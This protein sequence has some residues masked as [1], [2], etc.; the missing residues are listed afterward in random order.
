MTSS[1]AEDWRKS[2]ELLKTLI[3]DIKRCYL[4]SLIKIVRKRMKRD[5]HIYLGLLLLLWCAWQSIKKFL[6]CLLWKFRT[7]SYLVAFFLVYALIQ[8]WQTA[9]LKQSLLLGTFLQFFLINSQVIS[10]SCPCLCFINHTKK[11]ESLI[12]SSA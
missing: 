5:F 9:C 12:S 2:L 7:I 8:V 11:L 6:L 10:N 3:N 1:M 4:E